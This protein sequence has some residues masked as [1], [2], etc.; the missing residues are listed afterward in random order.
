MS[1][2]AR[3]SSRSRSAFPAGLRCVG[4]VGL[5]CE[6]VRAGV[7][8]LNS[9]LDPQT[10]L[11]MR[12]RELT[13]TR[14]RC[15]Y[16]RLHVLLRRDDWPS[17]HK[18]I[19]R[20][21]SKESLSIGTRSRKRRRACRYR[22]GQAEIDTANNYWAM[23]FVYYRLFD[24]RPFRSLTIVGCHTRDTIATCARTNFRANQVIEG[25]D[26][27]IKLR[28]KPRSILVDNGPEFVGCMLDQWAYFNKVEVDFSRLGKPADNADID[29]FDY[30]LRQECLNASWFR[31][32]ADARARNNECQDD[33][34]QNRPHTSLGNLTQAQFADQLGSSR[35]VA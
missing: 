18:R 27:L 35:K 25:L 7:T 31:S 22:S 6:R 14:V 32:I 5:S 9:R 28:G 20:I 8:P 16:R 23:G 29:V 34:S 10:A 15:G 12:V 24:E 11:R 1:G 3:S 26:R 13:E 17:N 21:Y 30:R 19:C 2:E 4:A 33:C